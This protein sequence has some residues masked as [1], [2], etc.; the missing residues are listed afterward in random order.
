MNKKNLV[1]ILLFLSTISYTDSI[2]TEDGGSVSGENK[3]GNGSDNYII[4]T[5]I[6]SDG[7]K[8]ELS[9]VFENGVQKSILIGAKNKANK[10]SASNVVAIGYKNIVGES[11]S[12][13]LGAWNQ[14]SGSSSIA[15]GM[16][17]N[18]IGKDSVAVG[19][20]AGSKGENS[21]AFGNDVK[22]IGKN[23]SVF[24]LGSKSSGAN[25]L[26]LGNKIDAMSDDSIAIGNGGYAGGKSSVSIG[27]NTKSSGTNAIAIGNTSKTNANNAIALGNKIEAMAANSIN[28]GNNGY[29]GGESSISI[30]NN[31]KSSGTN[32]IAL[33]TTS[34]T[35]RNNAI[36][37][38]N[39]TLSEGE[40]SISIGNGAKSK[41]KDSITIGK[42]AIAEQSDSIAIGVSATTKT[43]HGIAIGK[44][45]GSKEI[46]AISIGNNS[47]TEYVGDVAIGYMASSGSK[48]TK[49]GGGELAITGAT[50]IGAF[51]KADH[52]KTTAIGVS[53][54]AEEVS[55]TAI[56]ADSKATIE[57]SV[58]LGSESETT[59]QVATNKF[60]I[61]GMTF[62]EFAGKTPISVISIGSKGKE[63]QLQHVAAGQISKESTDAINGSQLYATNMVLGT[64]VDSAKS[65]LGGNAAIT[66]NGKLNMTNIGD[67]GKNT[68]HDAI[69]ASKTEV[70]ANNE[71]QANKTS[72]NIVLTSKD[73]KDGHRKYN[74]KLNDKITLG[75][76]NLILDGNSG[77]ITGLT[78][79]T[80]D[81]TN[82]TSGRAAT[83]DQLKAL[84][85]S[86]NKGQATNS[87]DFYVISGKSGTGNN[88]GTS[89]KEKMSKGDTLK[90]SA[91]DNLSISQSGKDFTYS[92]NKELKDLTSSEFKD[93][94]GNKTNIT[95]SGMSIN[96][97]KNSGKSVSVTKDGL[98][99]GGNKITNVAAGEKDTDA[100]NKSQLDKVKKELE[101][102]LDK[103]SK[104]S[105]TT[106]KSSD[107]NIVVTQKDG[108]NGS[109]EYDVKLNDKVTLGSG[110]KQV[111]LNGKT[112]EVKAGNVITNKDG[113]GTINGLTNKKWDSNNITSGQVATE[114]QL[115]ELDKKVNDTIKES[116]FNITSGKTGTGNAEGI[117]TE[118][119]KKDDTVKLNAGDNLSI[120]QKGK[121]FTYSLNKELKDLTSSE[122][123]DNSGNTTNITGDGLKIN[124]DKGDK[125]VS[126]TKDGLNNGGNKISNVGAGKAD[127]DGV[128]LKQLKDSRTEVKAENDSAINVKSSYDGDKNKYTY[129]LDVKT[130]NKTIL[131]DKDGKLKANVGTITTEVSNDKIEAKSSDNEKIAKTGDVAKAINTLGNNT[132]SF[133]ADKGNTDTQSLNKNGGLKFSIKGTDYIKTEAK[134]NEVSVDLT[135]KVKSDIAKGVAANSGVANAVA[136]AN[137]PQ[138][139]TLDDRRHNIAG[140][141]GY[142]N[143][144]HAFALGLSGLNEV[145]NVVYKVSGALN[146]KGHVSLGAGIGYQFGSS[147]NIKKDKEVIIEKEVIVNNDEVNNSIV[148]LNELNNKLNKRIDELEKKLKEFED[149]KMNEDDLY[150][151]DG[152]RLGIH[153]LTKSQEEMLMNIV[154]ELNEN[155]KNRKI[156][157][158]GYTD[159]VSGEN[160]NLELGLK[161]A[162]VVA[163]KLRELGLD[164]SISI[165]KVSSSGYNNIVETNKS[166][167]G[168][169]SNRR[170]EIELR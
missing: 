37:I 121:D 64:F 35:N 151:L 5:D 63:R 68:I 134:G 10:A 92:L 110:D 83:E 90:L 7:T 80:W 156:Y 96:S 128:N 47:K 166:S 103:E 41:E 169:S 73:D 50:A 114:D 144:E 59:K 45:A 108:A 22:A 53:S 143:G 106:V 78:N 111:E 81:S 137:L 158:T 76:K 26:A 44:E 146:T 127:T 51:S 107:N 100:V 161:R 116:G 56:G 120:K 162:N 147:V 3:R 39:E 85:D 112:G 157:I 130:D 101:D 32:A 160:L 122:F 69:K 12:V 88:L 46:H 38:G 62:G 33:G 155:Y 23:S 36:A 21:V 54:K 49:V 159:N 71:E 98:N 75:S 148:K 152:Y 99:N 150:T 140:S 70:I 18:S 102:K 164:M 93:K 124:S 11:N 55:S 40:N 28:I 82:I 165:R 133:G 141:Y 167:N 43:K 113:K 125:V 94:D 109:K 66:T 24:G 84:S 89:S 31:S 170:V 79:K 19:R 126:L 119:V 168:R 139:S 30:G 138:I 9:N 16:E 8:T 131:K 13:A 153:E 72:G 95:G 48:G 6:K 115:K 163:K 105:K 34:R 154:R 67:T 87:Y 135:D 104:A 60:S 97:D 142:Y 2:Y 17:S 42:N 77:T 86:L 14:A 132:L 129:T 52:K 29:A 58:A 118:K 57:K 1:A 20:K 149:I 117:T 65:I 4:G 91:G 123:K 25:S 136:M 15:I 27:N 145:G 74:V 61:N